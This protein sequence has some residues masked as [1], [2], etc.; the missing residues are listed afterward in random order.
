[1]DKIKELFSKPLYAGILG[2]VI[3]LIIGLPIL[4]WGLWPVKYTDGAPKDL[5]QDVKLDYLRMAVQSYSA[6]KDT[7]RAA[8][9]Y[10]ELGEGAKDLLN[11]LS[12]DP[13][14]NPVDVMNFSN[15]AQ[16][17]AGVIPE[18]PS[19]AASPTPL[20]PAEGQPSATLAPAVGEVVATA[21]PLV[22]E[23]PAAPAAEGAKTSPFVLLAVFC[24]L[25]LI[26]G[27]ALLYLLVFRKKG[28]ISLPKFG[29]KNRP[30]GPPQAHGPAATDYTLDGQEAPVAQFM[31]TFVMGDDLYD[32]SFSIDSA[33]GEF[34]G[35]CGVGISDTIGVGDPKKVT[36]F[37]VWLFDKDDIQTVTKVVMSEHAFTDNAIRQRLVSKG[38]P[39]LIKPN[40]SILLETA[41]LTLTARV[42][43]VI[44]GQGALPT[45]SYFERLTLELAIWRK[46]M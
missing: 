28:G 23:T 27:G 34:L 14:I 41:K 35:E 5:R 37:E 26:I 19:T 2:F 7:A 36:A 4:G 9:R 46:E 31:T 30:A 33:N 24:L 8:A 38:E 39:V 44:Y 22:G 17:S 15:V 1:M 18:V 3:G 32:D 42:H 20:P 40:D 43:E 13:T 16:S 10:Q 11:E 25:T 21:M 12:I 45:N 6:D 29:K